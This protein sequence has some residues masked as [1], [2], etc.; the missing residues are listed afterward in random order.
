MG[1]A[2]PEEACAPAA[3]DGMHTWHGRVETAYTLRDRHVQQTGRSVRILP[4]CAANRG[5]LHGRGAQVQILLS[6]RG[7]LEK[8][9]QALDR[10][11]G[12]L[13]SR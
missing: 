5:I 2:P 13:L 12:T 8:P 9:W 4:A 7:E 1:P 10:V 3:L 6:I 11:L